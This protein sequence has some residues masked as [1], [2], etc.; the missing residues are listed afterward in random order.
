MPQG[1]KETRAKVNY[2]AHTAVKA[3]GTP[4]PD[5]AKGELL[6]VEPLIFHL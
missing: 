2:Y 1:R 3:D 5:T 6:S 4:E